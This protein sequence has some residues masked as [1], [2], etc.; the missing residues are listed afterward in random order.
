MSHRSAMMERME[1][2]YKIERLLRQR[3]PVSIEDFLRELEVSRATFKRDLE[4]LRDRF[5]MPIDWDSEQRGYILRNGSPDSPSVLPGF[6]LTAS[7]V[8]ALLSVQHLIETLDPGLLAASLAPVK[9]RLT[10]ILEESGASMKQIRRRVRLLQ[11]AART[12]SPPNFSTVSSALLSRRQLHMTYFVRER[13]ERTE[14]DVSPQRLVHYRDNWYL[15]A[16]CHARNGLRTFSLDAIE[17]AEQLKP[18]AIDVTEQE[19]D[20]A[21]GSG[22]GIFAG[23]DVRHAKLRFS[24]TRSLWVARERWH[25]E[26]KGSYDEQ[27]RYVLE[28]PYSDPRE[29]LMDVLRNGAD[30]EVLAPPELRDAATALLV[31]TLA[32]YQQGEAARKNVAPR[33]SRG[34]SRDGSAAA[35]RSPKHAQVPKPPG[36]QLE[37]A[38]NVRSR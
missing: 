11:M 5:N 24:A 27:A 7:E 17:A 37:R 2:F 29:L 22:Y 10:K 15:D 32:Q 26:Q 12:V 31:R 4:Y 19:L 28:I 33:P 6:W 14:R 9:E 16:W 13:A 1:R 35:A 18:R 25:P 8:Q 21:L 3:R 23:A 36:N 30:V 20:R 34:R 38:S